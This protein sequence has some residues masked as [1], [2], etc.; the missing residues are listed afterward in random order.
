M[1]VHPPKLWY[2][3]FWSRLGGCSFINKRFYNHSCRGDYCNSEL[4]RFQSHGCC[5]PIVMNSPQVY[6]QVPRG[7]LRAWS[8]PSNQHLSSN[9]AAYL[10]TTPLTSITSTWF[11]SQDICPKIALTYSSFQYSLTHHP[12]TAPLDDWIWLVSCSKCPL[13]PLLT[14]GRPGAP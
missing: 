1:D 4:I 14:T 11:I 13:G 7:L 10:D 9:V 12:S 8:L 5:N 2:C 3:R 6:P